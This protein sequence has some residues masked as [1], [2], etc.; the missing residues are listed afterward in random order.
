MKPFKNLLGN[1]AKEQE[2]L[3]AMRAVLAEI[4]RERERFEILVEGSKA[5]A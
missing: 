2:T 1:G 3:E 4:Q 5:G